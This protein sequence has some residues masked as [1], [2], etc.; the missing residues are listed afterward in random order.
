[1]SKK[2]FQVGDV[3]VRVRS[4]PNLQGDT[5]K[6]LSVGQKLEV[7]PT[8]RTETD[9]YVWWKHAEGWSAERSLDGSEVYLHE[10][11]EPVS[12]PVEEPGKPV[13]EPVEEPGQPEAPQDIADLPEKG[14]L[15]LAE[16]SFQTGSV[17]VRVRSQPGL[18][19]E[20]LKYLDPGSV[21]EVDPASRT[22]VDGY[23]WWK[24]AEG[25]SAERSADGKEIYLFEPGQ[26]PTEP[27][28]AAPVVSMPT[29]LEGLPDGESLPMRDQIFKRLPVDLDQT[30]WWQYYGNNVFGYKNWRQGITWYQYSQS[31]HGGLDFG[32]SSTPG[33]PVYAG[34]EGVFEKQITSSFTPYGLFV[35]VG[36][37]SI[38]Y[39][40]LVNPRPL[41]PG[42]PVSPDTVVGEIQYGG[43]AHLHL[44][45]R[46]KQKWIV[47]PLLFMPQEMRDAIFAKFPP[48]AEYFYRDATW[49]QWQTPLDQPVLILSGPII[50]PHAR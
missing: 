47:N 35:T 8:S 14:H 19:G 50:G 5:V 25:W 43:A 24:H 20:S 7:D 38:I 27:S 1:M 29:T 15:I 9:G 6:Y 2:A 3:E 36:D 26:A 41:Q 16:K 48:S 11:V 18:L 49:T 34:V 23:V 17:P 22:E 40:H 44:E 13:S 28:R 39:G 46:Y 4:Q 21:L 42:Q 37:Y 32:N 10:L 45:M 33:V 12:E 30:Q 31:L